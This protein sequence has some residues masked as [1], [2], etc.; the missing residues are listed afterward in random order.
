MKYSIVLTGPNVRARIHI[1]AA[2][3]PRKEA[4]AMAQAALRHIVEGVAVA[5]EGAPHVGTPRALVSI[6]PLLTSGDEAG[7]HHKTAPVVGGPTW[8]AVEAILRG[9]KV[10][11]GV[12]LVEEDGGLR[13][14]HGQEKGALA[15]YAED[16]AP[17]PDNLEDV[18]LVGTV[19]LQLGM[20]PK[21][22]RRVAHA[23]AKELARKIADRDS[24]PSGGGLS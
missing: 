18:L 7:P 19:N 3:W 4:A 10:P 22:I 1:D 13:W 24:P 11:K 20:S 21:Q 9:V 6:G 14:R 23:V 12:S 8:E 15:F 16:R 17:D 5:I 2:Q